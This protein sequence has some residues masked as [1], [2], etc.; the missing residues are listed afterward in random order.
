MEDDNIRS[1]DNI[2]L[3][4][5]KLPNKRSSGPDGVSNILLKKLSEELC[6]P[7]SILLQ[8]FFN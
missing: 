4:V 2:K 7:S 8:L 5:L 3:L 1:C 6:K